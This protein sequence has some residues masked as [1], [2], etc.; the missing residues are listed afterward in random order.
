MVIGK[1]LKGLCFV[2][3]A[4]SKDFL[5]F[6][7]GFLLWGTGGALTSGTEEAWLYDALKTDGKENNFD[8]VLGKGV[9]YSQIA[10]GVS[11]VMGSLMATVNMYLTL[12]ASVLLILVSAIIA[13]YLPEYNHMTEKGTGGSWKNYL[14]TLREGANFCLTHKSIPLMIAFF[15]TVLVT[16]G[17]LD[18][19]DQLI[20]RSVGVPLGL[21]GAWGL[22]RYGMEALGGR[23]AYRF[24]KWFARLGIRSSFSI[25]LCLAL[26]LGAALGISAIYPYLTLLP[27]YG[28]FYFLMSAARVLF[29]DTLQQSIENQGRATVQSLASMVEAPGGILVYMVFGLVGGTG[30]LQ[31][32]ILAVTFWII[33]LSFLFWMLGN[34]LK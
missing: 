14:T 27:L 3:W 19:Y 26:I 34:K 31:G 11:F 15:A 16:A 1:L 17:V 22:I 21:V 25:Q 5:G 4:F 23:G 6:A 18:E 8:K 30:N 33:I 7:I 13:A 28:T 29:T 20:V 32:A 10:V 9:F 2:V 12:W 24:K